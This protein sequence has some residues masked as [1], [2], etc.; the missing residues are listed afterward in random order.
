M[1]L[2]VLNIVLNSYT[3]RISSLFLLKLLSYE[4]IRKVWY[5]STMSSMEGPVAGKHLIGLSREV[6][7]EAELFSALQRSKEYFASL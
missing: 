6:Q 5:F 7:K 4:L 2:L 1:I 3:L